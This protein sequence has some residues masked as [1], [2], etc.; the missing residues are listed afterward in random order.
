MIQDNSCYTYNLEEIPSYQSIMENIK[1]VCLNEEVHSGPY[2]SMVDQFN[3]R[4]IEGRLAK[5]AAKQDLD[6]WDQDDDDKDKYFNSIKKTRS[7][8]EGRSA[9]DTYGN[10]EDDDYEDYGDGGY[11]D[12]DDGGWDGDDKG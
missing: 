9:S 2:V 7:V 4:S 1:D 8:K 11:D 12:N 10:Y 5:K 6:V 3:K